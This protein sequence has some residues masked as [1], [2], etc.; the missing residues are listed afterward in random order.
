MAKRTYASFTETACTCGYLER[1]VSYPGLPIKYNEQ[2]NEYHITSGSSEQDRVEMVIYH[3]PFC[4]G[5]APESKRGTFF[6]ELSDEEAKRLWLLLNGIN[7]VAE[8]FQKL[9][10]PDGDEPY[11]TPEG[12]PKPTKERE[13]RKYEATR[14]LTYSNLSPAAEVQLTVYANDE[15]ERTVAAKYTGAPSRGA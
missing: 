2:F 11:Q 6:A 12:W 3:C 1:G 8:A 13:G 10:P 7:T 5:A 4:G 9:G 15:V 14:L